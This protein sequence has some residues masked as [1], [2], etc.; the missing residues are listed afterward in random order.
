MICFFYKILPL[1]IRFTI[2]VQ[3]GHSRYARNGVASQRR[4]YYELL[5]GES[6]PKTGLAVL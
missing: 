6:R 1:Y 3:A 2:Y 4:W 5:Q